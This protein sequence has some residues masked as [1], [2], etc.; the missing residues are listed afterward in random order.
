MKPDGVR[1]Q[2]AARRQPEEEL[3]LAG[4]G[5]Q[6]VMLMGQLLA[7]AGM[8][9]DRNVTFWPSYGPEMRGGTANC[10]VVVSD[11][12]VG[13]PVVS[14]PSVVVAMNEPSLDKFEPAL[15]PGGLLVINSSLIARG[16][17]RQ[18]VRVIEVPANQIADE[19]GDGRVA[20]MV[21]LG[22]VIG[23]TAVVD[24]ASVS[25]SLRKVLPQRR[26]G[27]IPLNEQA[28]ARGMDVAAGAQVGQASV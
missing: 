7:Y 6:G 21:V 16:T 8:L 1:Q 3:V 26:H 19:L 24:V 11:A 18:D 22:A 20:N 23:A 2:P 5:G 15:R 9:E 28:L 10:T 25:N 13:S 12:P 4:F 17:A 14:H 27:L